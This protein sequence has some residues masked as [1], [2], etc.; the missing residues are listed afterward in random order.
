MALNLGLPNKQ[1]KIKICNL[2]NEILNNQIPL[3]SNKTITDGFGTKRVAQ[4]ILK[5]WNIL[6]GINV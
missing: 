2:I 3:K 1:T 5:I 6:G 4:E